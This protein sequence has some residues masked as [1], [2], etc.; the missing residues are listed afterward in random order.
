MEESG[1]R[2][3][4]A[5]IGLSLKWGKVIRW[6]LRTN[7]KFQYALSIGAKIDLR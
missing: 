4:K 2:H 3:T 5:L 7:M 6:L 1:C